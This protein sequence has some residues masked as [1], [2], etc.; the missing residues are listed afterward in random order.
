[1]KGR[2]PSAKEKLFWNDLCQI[3]GCIA[4]LLDG[5]RNNHCSVHHTDGR[6]KPDAHKKVLPLCGGHHQ[7][8]TGAPWLIAVH[9]YKAQFEAKYGRQEELIEMCLDLLEKV[10]ITQHR[11][12]FQ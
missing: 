10:G 8:G 11:G 9:P 12:L 3:I 5:N 7:Q 1:M 4:C 6:T 2:N